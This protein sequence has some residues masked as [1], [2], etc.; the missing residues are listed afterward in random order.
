MQFGGIQARKKTQIF[1]RLPFNYCALSLQPFEHPVCSPDGTIFDLRNIYPYLKK[2][3]VNP[4]TGEKLDP[5]SLI[6]LNFY[7]NANDEYH[8]PATLRVFNDHTHIVAIKTTGNVYAYEA[9]ER[10]NIKV[11]NWTD[12]VSD[13]PFTRKDIITIQDP[14]NLENRNFSNFY[15]VKNDLKVDE[16][17][18]AKDNPLND[19][20][21]SAVGSAA[22][23]L[24]KI[25]S[26]QD[27]V[28]DQKQNVS[29]E[30]K[31]VSEK[32]TKV[33]SSAAGSKPKKLPYNA[34]PY[35]RGLAAASFTS[36]AMTPV[37][38]N[39]NALIDEE[40]FM[41]KE[42]KAKGYVRI[43][44][45]LGN[46][47]V[48][49]F[50]DKS[51]RTCFNFIMLSKQ[52]YYN[53]I[54]FHRKIK[55]FMIQGGDPTG[56]GKG[57]ESYWKKDFVDEF[58]SNLSHNERGLLSMA[59]RGKNTNSSQFFFTFRPCVHLDNKHTIFG[60]IVG[61]KDVL[62]KMETVPTDDSDR[63][64]NEIKIVNVTV[65][66][67]PYEEY[68]KNLEKKLNRQSTEKQVKK[69]QKNEKDSTTTW[70]G[71]KLSSSVKKE[72]DSIVG[73]YLKSAISKKR[74]LENEDDSTDEQFLDTVPK[75]P[76]P[77][78][79]NFDFSKW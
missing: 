34:A 20:N 38:V 44:T 10:L 57:G 63:P 3:G 73:K 45:N 43:M 18:N 41:F 8:C 19:I 71:N 14:H 49:L 64:L 9:I 56:T 23:V 40:E 24:N 33:T 25:S 67:D 53:G 78:G 47:N 50:C 21:I 77:T 13:E 51:P 27:K 79:Y 42:I 54:I 60:K 4:V 1:K 35:T 66:V 55:N 76:K 69:P 31:P 22:R 36:T 26:R 61:G 72:D 2:H 32:I 39:E 15:H 65:F 75:K 52:G 30:T 11:K 62:D 37:T 29:T 58:K 74:E 68:K 59:N 28:S 16:D 48:E 12:L 7:K 6:K 5:K 17:N 70:F 46:L